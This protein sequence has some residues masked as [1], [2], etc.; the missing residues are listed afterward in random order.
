[1]LDEHRVHGD[2]ASDSAA[3]KPPSLFTDA[4]VL[5]GAALCAFDL[6][7]DFNLAF[8]VFRL[9]DAD[10]FAWSLGFLLLVV[11]GYWAMGLRGKSLFASAGAKH[12]PFIGDDALPTWRNKLGRFAL[13][14]PVLSAI[15]VPIYD[16]TAGIWA[17]VCGSFPQYIINMSHLLEYEQR[18][19]L[20]R[21]TFLSLV[22]SLTSLCFGP[23]NTMARDDI[24]PVAERFKRQIADEDAVSPM[25]WCC[26]CCSGWSPRWCP[27]NRQLKEANATFAEYRK[28]VG[29]R[30]VVLL[31][32][33]LIEVIHF[34]PI[35]IEHFVYH[36]INSH[37]FVGYLVAFN[38]P[39][40][41][42]LLMAK[43][44]YVDGVKWLY[45]FLAPVLAL[46]V[47]C[48]MHLWGYGT[49]H[50]HAGLLAGIIIGVLF[51]LLFAWGSL[52]FFENESFVLQ[53]PGWLPVL[54]VI[55]LVPCVLAI[56]AGYKG[57]KTR[58]HAAKW[59]SHLLTIYMLVAYGSMGFLL[60]EGAGLFTRVSL[61]A[62]YA[63]LVLIATMW[64]LSHNAL[65]ALTAHTAYGGGGA[66]LDKLDREYTDGDPS[67]WGVRLQQ[68]TKGAAGLDLSDIG[69]A[70]MNKAARMCLCV[71]NDARAVLHDAL[72][73]QLGECTAL[74]SLNLAGCSGLKA[75]P[76]LSSLTNLTRLSLA[77][78]SGLRALPDL[79]SFT[80]LARLNLAGC[81]GLSFLPG[82][83]SLDNLLKLNL[84]GCSGLNALPD[85]SSMPNL[86]V[87]DDLPRHL[88]VWRRA[89]FKRYARVVPDRFE[90]IASLAVLDLSGQRRIRVLPDLSPFSNLRALDLEGCRRL[91]AL[92]G[93]S[94][95]I[96]LAEL[97]LVGCSGL[98][99][100]P[101]LSLLTNLVSLNLAGCSGLNTL[102]DFSS[103]PNL[104]VENLPARLAGGGAATPPPPMAS[105]AGRVRR[106]GS[107]L[108]GF[109]NFSKGTQ[110]AV[111]PAARS[112]AKSNAT[113]TTN[114]RVTRSRSPGSG[115]AAR[116]ARGSVGLGRA[117][118]RGAGVGGS[119]RAAIGL[120]GGPA[121][122]RVAP[123]GGS[124]SSQLLLP[125][126]P[127]FDA[128]P[129]L[130]ANGVDYVAVAATAPTTA[131]ELDEIGKRTV[132]GGNGGGGGGC[133]GGGEGGHVGDRTT[134]R[135]GGD[136]G[137]G[138]GGSARSDTSDNG[139]NCGD[140]GGEGGCEGDG[141]GGNVGGGEAG[142][143]GGDEGGGSGGTVRSDTS[144]SGS[145]SGGSA[146]SDDSFYSAEGDAGDTAVT[147]ATPRGI[148]AATA[149]AGMALA[150]LPL[151]AVAAVA[152]AVTTV[153][154][155]RQRSAAMSQEALLSTPLLSAG[156][157]ELSREGIDSEQ[158]ANSTVVTTEL[159]QDTVSGSPGSGGAVPPVQGDLGLGS[160]SWRGPGAGGSGSDSGSGSG[161][162]RA[163][164]AH[165]HTLA[166]PTRWLSAVSAFCAQVDWLDVATAVGTLL[167][168]VSLLLL[169][170]LLLFLYT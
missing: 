101:D 51:G 154:G 162:G 64:L 28:W 56:E 146:C 31:P 29:R 85:L 88:L 149:A 152:A 150:A 114:A 32:V 21:A 92:P 137:G 73:R 122:A 24:K 20:S 57:D 155:R 11:L 169:S 5:L 148:A 98:N 156:D 63:L 44:M 120:V 77:G 135:E 23:I 94:S 126:Q 86:T 145:S 104:K 8:N 67:G 33:I 143:E 43:V 112:L 127:F 84:A 96:N 105:G 58:Q 164:T 50:G 138:S 147:R 82:L 163:V 48:G 165:M 6:Y 42:F 87:S 19:G 130:A 61:A 133:E 131:L 26:C 91:R 93:I 78:C 71:C 124:H 107:G 75:L 139:E 34:F 2:A 128:R 14:T 68:A 132:C 76:D 36:G 52:L 160:S 47:P 83:S 22:G 53:H 39:K 90:D 38:A 140:G 119:G 45:V 37:S 60:R 54:V 136:E 65:T 97:N 15:A 103:L 166:T 62:C 55:P 79:S 118:W 170:L 144:D 110:G 69:Y 7:G 106:A 17:L 117:S 4:L 46:V 12:K 25:A 81:S 102:P 129:G 109:F 74:R 153:G 108:F 158:L 59:N 9:Q 18:G 168:C 80:N 99:T 123:G 167:L 41:L 10:Y 157:P 35:L 134:D 70:E 3:E 30:L 89:C 111:A 40:L 13:A 142:G 16:S 1:M 113:T 125:P 116:S 27:S 72:L 115:G 66:V 151:A 100:L 141:E 95:L 161:N 121:G 49:I 159:A